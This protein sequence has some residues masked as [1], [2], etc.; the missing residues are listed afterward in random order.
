MRD[1]ARAHVAAH[2]DWQR[3]VGRYRD[4]YQAL[5][6]PPGKARTRAAA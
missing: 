3:N 4:V 6:E 2:H 1:A 5:L